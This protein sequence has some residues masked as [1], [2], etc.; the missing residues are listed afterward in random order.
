MAVALLSRHC[1][2]LC[3]ATNPFAA[4]PKLQLALKNQ[5][6]GTA[7]ETGKNCQSG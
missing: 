2:V 3:P 5:R 6:H 4:L 7:L 1:G